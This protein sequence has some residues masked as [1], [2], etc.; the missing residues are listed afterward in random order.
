MKTTEKTLI[1]V[2]VSSRLER[3]E[4]MFD[5][6]SVDGDR[7]RIN[8]S[9]DNLEDCWMALYSLLPSGARTG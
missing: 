4:V 7:E 1:L 5:G 8:K 6:C 2:I 9:L 3:K